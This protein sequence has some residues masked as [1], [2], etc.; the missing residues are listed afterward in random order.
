LDQ[1]GIRD[2]W[3]HW[4]DVGIRAILMSIFKWIFTMS[5][6]SIGEGSLEEYIPDIGL[7]CAFWKK[8]MD[9]T[10][11]N[12]SCNPNSFGTEDA[13]FYAFMTMKAMVEEMYKDQKKAKQE[14]GPS[15]TTT[16]VEGEGGDPT[17][18]LHR[19]HPL[20]VRVGVLLLIM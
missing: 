19:L 3:Y 14:S 17:K 4:K 9:S 6:L 12:N 16:K 7:R 5:K 18:I 1:V 8:E 10:K 2:I 20:L 15:G 13:L 11:D